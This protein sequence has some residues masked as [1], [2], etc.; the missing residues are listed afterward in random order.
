M[1]LYFGKNKMS[2][3]Y[4]GGAPV[5]KMY[6]G[7]ELVYANQLPLIIYF[8]DYSWDILEEIKVKI[9]QEE[10]A[11]KCENLTN[12]TLIINCKYGSQVKIT[13]PYIEGYNFTATAN[14]FI[15]TKDTN[16]YIYNEKPVAKYQFVNIAQGWHEEP[17]WTNEEDEWI[18]NFTARAD[19]RLPGGWFEYAIYGY[20][21]CY[22]NWRMAYSEWDEE[23]QDTGPTLWYPGESSYIPVPLKSNYV[24]SLDDINSP[25]FFYSNDAEELI[26]IDDQTS[27]GAYAVEEQSCET[28]T[29]EPKIMAAALLFDRNMKAFIQNLYDDCYGIEIEYNNIKGLLMGDEQEFVIHALTS[30]SESEFNS[31]FTDFTNGQY[32]T[33]NI[34]EA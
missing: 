32:Y 2:A 30:E 20:T 29:L 10:V 25:G 24:P 33:I 17:S 4:F 26:G 3:A 34:I 23:T 21:D 6:M 27:F 7:K 13:I 16:I 18:F 5:Q 8:Y 9:D 19:V 31:I 14:S 15:I 12:Q 28:Q 1:S 22:V 11:Y